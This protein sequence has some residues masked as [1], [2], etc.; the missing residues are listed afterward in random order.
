ML[1]PACMFL[2]TDGILE[3]TLTQQHCRLRCI[4]PLPLFHHLYWYGRWYHKKCT[5]AT[6]SRMPILR[7]SVVVRT[8]SVEESGQNCDLSVT[9]QIMFVALIGPSIN[10]NAGFFWCSFWTGDYIVQ[11]CDS[12][13]Q[14]LSV[15]VIFLLLFFLLSLNLM[16]PHKLQWLLG[17]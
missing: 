6:D 7:C 13:Q 12:Y 5:E 16:L 4:H 3:C 14:F 2:A 15:I 11:V 1:L 17:L 10:C 9:D 8:G